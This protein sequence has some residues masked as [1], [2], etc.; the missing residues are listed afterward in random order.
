[1]AAPAVVLTITMDKDGSVRVSGPIGNK[2]LCYGILESAR[3]AIA[4]WHKA[5]AQGPQI[6]MAAGPLP[7]RVH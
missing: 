2:V 5:Q 6:E 7:D 3:E 1:M 4:D